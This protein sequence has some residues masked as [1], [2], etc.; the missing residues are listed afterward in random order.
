MISFKSGISYRLVGDN[1]DE[2]PAIYEASQFEIVSELIPS[3]WGITVFN[4]SIIILGPT[5]WQKED[6]W[7]SSYDLDPEALRI[8]KREAEIIFKEQNDF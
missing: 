1:S 2:M 4:K 8:Y 7:D 5:V 6:F 3:N